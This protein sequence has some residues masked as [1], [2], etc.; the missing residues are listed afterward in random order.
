MIDVFND[1]QFLI[2]ELSEIYES[3]SRNAKLA[4][5]VAWTKPHRGRRTSVIPDRF[6]VGKDVFDGELFF[7][8]RRM[9]VRLPYW[10]NDKR[11]QDFFSLCVS[12]HCI[13]DEHALYMLK[14]AFP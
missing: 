14:M 4:L 9:G 10:V 8:V 12:H 3:K 2:G 13:I 7:Q 6:G 1:G 11:D 5:A